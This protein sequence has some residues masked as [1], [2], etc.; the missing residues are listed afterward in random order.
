MLKIENLTVTYPDG[1]KAVSDLSLDVKNGQHAALVGA[2]GAG[3]TSLL[4]AVAGVI[5]GAGTISVDGT[6]LTRNTV[7]EI[8]RKTGMV[9]QNPDDQLFMPTIYD[10]IAFGPRN[11]GVDEETVRH[12]VEDRLK[13][14]GI[15]HLRDKTALKLSGGEK[16]MAALAT[17]LAM[18]PAL[19]LFDEP[20]AF[21]DP[22]ARRKLIQVLKS[23]PHT[24]L[25]TT[26]DLLFAKEVCE[27]TIVMKEGKISAIGKSSV[28]LYDE[29][30]MDE[31]GVEAIGIYEK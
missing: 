14:L 24:M 20:T 18:K 17:V 28:L 23:L 6:V 21:L 9:F 30:Q 3:K 11:L 29:K 13:L 5:P 27:D 22:K 10:D 26:H 19:M 31:A 8:R 2:N 16:R 4:L 1:T 15:E 25:I 12:R 7:A